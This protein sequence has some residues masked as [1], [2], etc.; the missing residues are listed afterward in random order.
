MFLCGQEIVNYICDDDDIKAISFVGSN[1]HSTPPKPILFYP[2]L[3]SGMHIYARAAARGKRVQSNIGAKNHAIVMPD[4]SADATLDALVA[5]GFGAAGQR[6]E[7]LVARAKALKVNAGTEAGA[8]LGPVISKEVK[9]QICKLVQSGVDSGA[10][11]VLDGRNTVVY[12]AFLYHLIM[13]A[14]VFA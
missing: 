12:H 9:D 1:N 4:A 14:L 11:L 8:D 5:A 3:E 6:E 13:C 7:E 2:G 10:R